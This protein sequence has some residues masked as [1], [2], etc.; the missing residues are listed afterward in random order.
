MISLLARESTLAVLRNMRPGGWCTLDEL[1]G[2]SAIEPG[3]LHRI[4]EELTEMGVLEGSGDDGGARYR[5]LQPRITLNLD[6]RELPPGPGYIL[7]VVRFYLV[8]LSNLVERCKEAGG[9]ALHAEALVSIAYVRAQLPDADKGL[10][11]CLR[12]GIQRGQCMA[13]LED[14]IQ[15]GEL[16]DADIGRVRRIYLTALRTL[17]DR[18]LARVDDSTGKLLLRLAAR[19]LLVQGDEL[20]HRFDLLEGIPE[21]YLKQV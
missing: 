13:A 10:L 2:A 14:R 11:H 7:D 6:L 1:A 16:T 5:L 20:V 18:L 19:E 21:K 3:H 12:R 17:V 4:L 9:P 8:L 15:A